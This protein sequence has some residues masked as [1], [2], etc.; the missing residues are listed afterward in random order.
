MTPLVLA[1]QDEKLAYPEL[2]KYGWQYIWKII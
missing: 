2:R 1:A